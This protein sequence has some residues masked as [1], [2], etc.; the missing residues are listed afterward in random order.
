MKEN[1][2]TGLELFAGLLMELRDTSIPLCGTIHERVDLA[3]ECLRNEIV[4]EVKV[5]NRKKEYVHQLQIALNHLHEQNIL[6]IGRFD[7]A[8]SVFKYMEKEP[9]AHRALIAFTIM[10]KLEAL[11]S[12]LIGR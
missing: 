12:F 6:L 4:Q 10:E 3:D 1:R 5:K 11:D 7:D 2:Y 8:I 9:D